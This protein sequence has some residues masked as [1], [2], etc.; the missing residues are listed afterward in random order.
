[1]KR[2]TSIHSGFS[3]RQFLVGG[4]VA[5]AAITMPYVSSTLAQSDKTVTVTCWGGTY[6][7]AVEKC[8]AKPFTAETGIPVTLIDNAD[9]AKLKAQVDMKSV[10]WDVFDS[11]GSQITAGS[12]EG[13]W[14]PVDKGIIDRSD[15]ISPGADDYVGAFFY[16]GGVGWDK[17]RFP[18]GKHP[19]DFPGLW[20]VKTFPGRRGLSANIGETLEIALLADG[21]KPHELYPLDVERGFASLDKIKPHVRKWIES[22]P[23]TVTLLSS[24]EIDFAYAYIGRIK[25]AQDGGASV[26]MSYKQT[27][28]SLE[29][30]AVPKYSPNREAGMRYIAFCLRPD[31]QAAFGDAIFYTPNARKAFPLVSESARS[32]M[33]DMES[34]DNAVA[35][36]A[37]WA[38]KYTELQKRYTEWQLM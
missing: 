35:N 2:K 22:T 23:Q 5:A 27:L 17:S 1:V 8:W 14:E 24:N 10:Q 12:R 19:V 34:P 30:F 13:M 29:F 9:L 36:A 37:W 6:R 26:E 11:V 28:N 16:G 32:F 33:P 18:D 38:D 25:T 15:L 20:D 21:V 3:R 31:R 4:T 7:D